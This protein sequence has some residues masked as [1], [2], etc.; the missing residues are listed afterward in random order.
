MLFHCGTVYDAALY[1]DKRLIYY[2]K[3]EHGVFKGYKESVNAPLRN[4]KGGV[5]LRAHRHL[6]KVLANCL[7][8]TDFRIGGKFGMIP[9]PCFLYVWFTH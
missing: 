4:V 9:P 8:P 6:K 2:E 1:P 7:L 3:I 5:Y